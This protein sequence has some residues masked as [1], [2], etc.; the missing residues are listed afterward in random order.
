[1]KVM[2]K[3]SWFL[4][5]QPKAASEPQNHLL[6]PTEIR[7]IVDA[8]VEDLTNFAATP[9]LH[10]VDPKGDTPLH[11]AARAGNLPLCDLF[12][13]AGADPGAQ[14]HESQTPADVAFGEGHPLAAQLLSSLITKPVDGAPDDTFD[15]V[16]DFETP[17]G[18]VEAI[19]GPFVKEVYSAEQNA[20][21]NDLDDLLGFEP[22]EEPE[23]FF[24]QSASITASGAFVALVSQSPMISTDK[25]GDWEIDLSPVQIAGEGIG[26]EAIIATDQG[27]EHDYLKVRNRGRQSVKRAV[28]QLGTRLSINPEICTAW[29]EEILKMGSFTLDDIDTLATL[30][31]GNGDPE[32]LRIN[33]QR[34]LES[35]GLELF[36]QTIE[37]GVRLWDAR[38]DAS[39]DEL[40]EAIEAAFSRSTR[41][42]GTQRFVMDKSNEAQL[43]EPMVRANQELQLGILACEA[44]IETIL[45]IVDRLRDGFADAGSVT[46]R[47]I[48]PARPDHAETAEFFAAADTLRL[49]Q[50]NGRIMDGKRRRMA[51]E[52]L[53]ALDL[54]LA[55]HKE[56]VKSVER[57]QANV[58]DASRLDRLISIFDVATE[59]LILEHL[60]YARRFA[61][62]NAEDG[63]DLEDVFQVAFKGLQRS[64]RR[65]DPERGIR[66]VIY[67]AFWMKQ[68]L[69]RW[70]ADEAALIRVPVHRHDNL[71]KLDRAMDKLDFMADGTVSDGD[72][73]IELGW[74]SEE[75]RQFRKIPRQAEYPE[76]FA[77][78]DDLLSEPRAEDFFDQAETERIVVDLLA[79]LPDRQADVIR[80]RFGIGRADE[81]TLEEVGQ[82][83]GVTRERIRQIEAKGLA[84]LSHP[85]RKRRLQTLLGM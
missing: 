38:S 6:D 69:A 60:P 28:M 41:L 3:L 9:R 67:S 75:V 79:E 83:Y 46:L 45:E 63:E 70:R 44:A 25:E 78:W 27:G 65:F 22:E 80:M 15:D 29:A 48:I 74:T 76:G 16:P 43:L 68:A 71:A 84:F 56:I 33:L 7:L 52:A 42:P 36:D 23:N 40:A 73:A 5:S 58:E 57:L 55:F 59:H 61:A 66:F 17:A 13:R 53:E 54:S 81:M 21:L 19:S 34:N 14:N 8:R 30:C 31:E 10:A 2:D 72:L 64:T 82:I 20:G 35:A 77:V 37:D 47:S 24:S 51:L 12:I 39:P 85:G 1:M 32:E 18:E 26:S 49:W 11:L 50:V 4:G 62:R